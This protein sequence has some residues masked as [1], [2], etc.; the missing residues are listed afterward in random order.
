MVKCIK[1]GNKYIQIFK[2]I[3]HY[4]FYK[5][6]KSQMF[7]LYVTISRGRGDRDRMVV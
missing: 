3:W 6:V 1:H 4:S 5:S 2:T 7:Y